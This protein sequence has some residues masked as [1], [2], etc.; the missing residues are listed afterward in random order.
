[1]PDDEAWRAVA[2]ALP[3][4]PVVSDPTARQLLQITTSP[5]R[6]GGRY[7]MPQQSEEVGGATSAEPIAE[8]AG[9]DLQRAHGDPGPDA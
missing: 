5:G 8:S 1:V 9:V 7:Q 4:T 6:G 2:T 3:G